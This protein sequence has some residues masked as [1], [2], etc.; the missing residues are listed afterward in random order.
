[1][2]NSRTTSVCLIA[3]ASLASAPSALSAQPEDSQEITTILE[4]SQGVA[5][6][7]LAVPR[8]T[9]SAMDTATA[10]ATDELE[11]VLLD[12]LLYTRLFDIQDAEILAVLELS[13]DRQQDFL[14]YR[15]LGNQAVLQAEITADP[16]H[17]TLEARVLDL[18]NY[19]AICTG[20]RYRGTIDQARR[21]AHTYADV[22]VDCFS[23]QRGLALTQLVFASNRGGNKELFMMDYDGANQRA[24]SDHQTVTMAPD[25]GPDGA[26]IAYMSYFSRQPSLYYLDL[27][28]GLK[29]TI[30][31][32]SQPNFSPSLSPDSREVAFTRSLSGNSE[33]FIISRSGGEPRRVTDNPRIDA[34]PAFSPSGREIAFTSDR[35]GNPQIY[36]MNRDG[37]QLRR[38]TR[39]GTNNDG[40]DWHPDGTKLTYA[41]RHE[42]GNRFDI[43]VIDLITLENRLLTQGPGSHE[44]PSFSPDGRRIVFES[45]RGGSRQIWTVDVDGG[46]LRKLTSEGENFAP[47]WS[48]Y[49]K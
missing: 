12:D 33:I 22:L 20:K 3:I 41:H 37:S 1:M 49:L 5:R 44:G 25:W 13:G 35:A 14:Q 48:S 24:V 28:S 26:G 36:V 15:S 11:R 47:S 46:S 45:T 23:G 34:N 16:G 19:K 17:L 7:R 18:S 38:V 29:S 43:A 21:I 42:S 8:M 30:L 6:V 4:N 39:E 32:D 9:R 27:K 2:F 31:E 10:A 40:A